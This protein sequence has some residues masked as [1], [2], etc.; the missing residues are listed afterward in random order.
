MRKV[1]EIGGLVAGAVLIVFGVV[2]I[3][4]GFNGRSTVQ[5]NLKQEQITG[6]SDM[7]PAL[8]KAE[9]KQAGL[10]ATISFPTKS[11]AGKA[12]TNGSLARTFAQYMRIHALEATGGLVYSQMPRYATADGKGT[13]D[14]T[15][16]LKDSKGN[17]VANAARDIWIQETALTT[18]LNTSFMAEQLSLFGI[19]TGVALLLSGVGFVILAL[20]GALRN[21]QTSFIFLRRWMAEHEPRR[22]KVVPTA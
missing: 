13:N 6:S 3:V 12:I 1:L 2:A 4:M 21:P 7:T 8:I 17:P 11:V 16:A 18:A 5:S 20:G 10:P 19:V 14:A 9:A 15:L 22:G